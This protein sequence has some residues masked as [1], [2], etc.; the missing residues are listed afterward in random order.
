MSD[1]TGA[2]QFGRLVPAEPREAPEPDV[3]M[4]HGRPAMEWEADSRANAILADRA[5]C[6]AV[7]SGLVRPS[8]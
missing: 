5:R 6:N 1:V 2:D 8:C 4:V 3:S 7:L